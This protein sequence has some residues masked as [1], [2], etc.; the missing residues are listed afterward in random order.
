MDKNVIFRVLIED[1]NKN[2]SK[3]KEEDIDLFN[4]IHET[5]IE[6]EVANSMFN[7]V[8]EPQLIDLAIH[9]EDVARS[10]FNYLISLAKKRE[11]KNIKV[12]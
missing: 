11:L 9:A 7:S 6:M 12:I 4:S 1:I 5:I 10:R 3:Y 8:S 2:K